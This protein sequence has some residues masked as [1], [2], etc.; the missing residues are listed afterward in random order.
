MNDVEYV[1]AGGI[2]AL[3]MKYPTA[4]RGGLIS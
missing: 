1:L 2:V 4:N 3:E